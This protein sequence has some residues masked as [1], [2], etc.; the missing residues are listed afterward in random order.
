M[1]CYAKL[2]L[3]T[4]RV[5]LP[6]R[7]VSASWRRPFFITSTVTRSVQL[8]R[9]SKPA[10]SSELACR[11]ALGDVELRTQQRYAYR[12]RRDAVQIGSTPAVCAVI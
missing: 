2:V 6:G 7:R 11:R 8:C 1:S 3:P 12:P 10:P 4:A 5:F 9:L